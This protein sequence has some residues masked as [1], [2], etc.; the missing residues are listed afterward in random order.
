MHCIEHFVH[1]KLN[2]IQKHTHKQTHIQT[3]KHIHKHTRA[4]TRHTRTNTN[5]Y[6]DALK[7]VH[8]Q[9]TQKLLNGK[10]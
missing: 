10:S 6:A 4:N 8:T 5:T 2:I 1:F 3:H 9:E 7:H